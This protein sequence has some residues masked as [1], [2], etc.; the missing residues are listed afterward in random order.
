MDVAKRES[1]PTFIYIHPPLFA[2]VRGN[3]RVHIL[4][5]CVSSQISQEA[6]AFITR[7]RFHLFVERT[8]SGD[9]IHVCD[10]WCE[11]LN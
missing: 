8:T 10:C 1:V 6:A 11:S 5:L 2:S 4:V 9:P 7:E 3:A